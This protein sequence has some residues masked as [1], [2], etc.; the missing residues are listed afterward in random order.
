[1]PAQARELDWADEHAGHPH[2]VPADL[3]LCAERVPA[4]PPRPTP[5]CAGPHAATRRR[6]CEATRGGRRRPHPVRS[7]VYNEE[8]VPDLL[9]TMGALAAEGTTAIFVSL[10]LRSGACTPFLI[11]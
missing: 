8:L 10:E 1:M 3:L 6:S 9:R 5:P 7:C 2:G 4:A 11:F